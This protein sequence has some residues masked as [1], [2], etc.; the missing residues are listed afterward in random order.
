[1]LLCPLLLLLIT[2]KGWRAFPWF[3][4]YSAFAVCAGIG[5]FVTSN[6]RARYF[7]M[8]WMTEAGYDVLGTCVMFEV[9]RRVFGN[10]GR[11]W[12]PRLLFPLL[13]VMSAVLTLGRGPSLPSGL[14]SS[15]M[16]A[17]LLGEIFVRFLEV[18]MFATLVTLVPLHADA[19]DLMCVKSVADEAGSFSS[20]RPQSR[21][22][23]PQAAASKMSLL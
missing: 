16:K 11:S 18:I 15:M 2:R 4:T 12:W 10:L 23:L 5:R 22:N 3:F 9:S 21:A 13:I 17:I 20:Y 6:H 7:W 8:Y 14:S 19:R 1:M